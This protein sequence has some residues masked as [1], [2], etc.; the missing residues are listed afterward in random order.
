MFYLKRLALA[1]F[2]LALVFA[3]PNWPYF[4]AQTRYYLSFQ[5][6]VEHGGG[7]NAQAKNDSHALPRD[8]IAIPSLGI[9]APLVYID[10]QAEEDFQRALQ[11]GV[12]HYTGTALPGQYGNAYY[13]GHSSDYLTAPGEYKTVFAL[14]PKILKGEVIYITDSAGQ[15]YTYR[16]LETK[17]VKP[18]D[19]SVLAQ[20]HGQ[21]RLSLQT[22]Y[23][24]GTALRRFIVIAELVE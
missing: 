2:L 5:P 1:A 12:V 15:G 21:R 20:D 6:S 3:I 13:F 8:T 23:P 18:S 16:V 19:L 17:V 24:L 4:Y 7:E 10:D 14:L 9:Q 11:H 22:S